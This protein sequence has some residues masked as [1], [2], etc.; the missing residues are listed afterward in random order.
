V[1][2]CA[3][4]L[5]L[6]TSISSVCARIRLLLLF[7]MSVSVPL[8]LLAVRWFVCVLVFVFGNHIVTGNVSTLTTDDNTDPLHCSWCLDLCRCCLCVCWYRGGVGT[9]CVCMSVWACQFAQLPH[10]PETSEGQSRTLP[11]TNIT[12][13]GHGYVTSG[14]YLQHTKHTAKYAESQV[15]EVS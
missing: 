6:S 8:P 1:S 12:A 10:H 11:P 4:S 2:V 13:S 7:V 3:A 15:H 14:S 9:V 5:L